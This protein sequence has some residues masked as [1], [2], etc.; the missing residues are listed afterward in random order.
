MDQEPKYKVVSSE[1]IKFLELKPLY[2]WVSITK[3]DYHSQ[4]SP[5]ITLELYCGICKKE[6]PFKD[7]RSRGGGEPGSMPSPKS[8]ILHYTCI[9]TGCGIYKYD[10]FA[11]FDLEKS[12]IRKIGQL[13][14]WSI[15]IDKDME[16]ILKDETEYYKKAMIC[17][18]QG[19]GIAA[20][21][22]YR[23]ILENSFNNILEKMLGVA[24][25]ENDKELLETI[26]SALINKV[27]E[28]RIKLIK[29]KVPSYMQ[30]GG[31]NP[32]KILYSSLS[33]GIHNQDEA[34][35]LVN[36]ENIRISL[37]YIIKVINRVIDEKELFRKAIRDIE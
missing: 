4:L 27:S 8:G 14:P 19:F 16:K 24:T 30:I 33:D 23:R 12:R 22:Y 35:C 3:P 37:S 9:C 6:R 17:E 18:S 32:F 13:P 11:D 31:N 28:E 5:D 1:L 2:S 15:Q 10:F 29:D 36:S 7:Y 34:S 20:F 21:A 25:E 26:N